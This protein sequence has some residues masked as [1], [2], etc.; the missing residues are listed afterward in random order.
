MGTKAL[1]K[2]VS[3][4]M[5]IIDRLPISSAF[6][7]RSPTKAKIQEVAQPMNSAKNKAAASIG[8]LTL[9]RQPIA[10]AVINATMPASNK[11]TKKARF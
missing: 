2:K 6:L 3:T 7:T 8:K 1:D 10:K 5:I 4:K 9:G 11:R